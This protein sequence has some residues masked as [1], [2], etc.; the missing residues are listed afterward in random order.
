MDIGYLEV[1]LYDYAGGK[2]GADTQQRNIYVVHVGCCA[3]NNRRRT[4]KLEN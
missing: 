4:L 2:K 1:E 3:M